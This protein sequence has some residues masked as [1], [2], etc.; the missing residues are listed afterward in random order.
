MSGLPQ[1][2]R[3]VLAEPLDASRVRQRTDGRGGKL[4]Y[5]E[6]HDV[7]RTA[8]AV[9]GFGQ[10]GHE[11]VDLRPLAPVT[12]HNKDQK[13][14]V[15][16]GYICTIRLTVAGCVPVSGV[17]FG[18]ATEYRESAAVTAHELAAKEAES[19]ALKRALKNYGDQFGLALYD[20]A[21]ATSGHVTSSSRSS[22][23]GRGAA[24]AP[25]GGG[26]GT[27]GNQAAVAPSPDPALTAEREKTLLDLAAR[28][29][30]LVPEWDGFDKLTEACSAHRGDGSWFDRAL[31][32]MRANLENA[33][34]A[35][36][37]AAAAG[38]FK[39][40]ANAGKFTAGK[41]AEERAA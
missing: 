14:G 17:G 13:A 15:C 36:E 34:A 7:I 23:R 40:P 35:V 28:Y 30:G 32:K 2:T 8:N 27:D 3:D 19:D 20:K 38:G 5:L 25:A 18:D 12:V 41:D 1:E 10:W 39:V 4:S 22:G 29:A 9:F 37:A 26:G 31:V 6:T 24:S 16:V 33:P 21:A 11:V